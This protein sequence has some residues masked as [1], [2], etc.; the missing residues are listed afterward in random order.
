MKERGRSIDDVKKRVLKGTGSSGRGNLKRKQKVSQLLR[1]GLVFPV[2]R[3]ARKLKEGRYAAH[4]GAG[5]PVFLAAV[6]EYLT[7]EV[8]GAA[9]QSISV[10]VS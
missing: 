10:I 6:L 8:I 9:L 2:G 1:A 7:A 4:V 5:A 3:I